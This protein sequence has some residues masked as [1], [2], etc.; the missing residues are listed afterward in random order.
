MIVSR[1]KMATVRMALFRSLRTAKQTLPGLW[2][3]QKSS[4]TLP[5][6]ELQRLLVHFP[7]CDR[8]AKGAVPDIR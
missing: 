1:K 7:P 6:L 3:P 4:L 8:R 2:L 5:L